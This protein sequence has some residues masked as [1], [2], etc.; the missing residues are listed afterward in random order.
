MPRPTRLPRLWAPGLSDSSLSLIVETS[1]HR[2]R[3]GSS[4]LEPDQ[5]AYLVDHAAHRGSVFQLACPV[6]LVEAEPNKGLSLIVLAADRAADLRNLDG[7]FP[8]G[9]CLTPELRG[10]PHDDQECRTPFCRA[11]A[12][13]CAGS[14]IGT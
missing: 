8:L 1:L 5:M 7:L 6:Q 3:S 4:L 11:A 2:G 10:R 9:H 13:P 14:G 12:R